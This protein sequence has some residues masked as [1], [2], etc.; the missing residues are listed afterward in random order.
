MERGKGVTWS[1]VIDVCSRAKEKRDNL[2]IGG[3]T[4]LSERSDIMA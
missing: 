4:S 1:G 2:N 3:S